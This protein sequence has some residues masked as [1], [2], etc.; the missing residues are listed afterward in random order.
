MSMTRRRSAAP[1]RWS[2]VAVTRQARSIED[3]KQIT[4]HE[5]AAIFLDVWLGRRV[6]SS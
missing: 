3:A 6:G 2:S 1:S 5:P 4:L